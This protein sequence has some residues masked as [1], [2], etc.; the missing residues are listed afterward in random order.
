MRLLNLAVVSVTALGLALASSSARAIEAPAIPEEPPLERYEEIPE[1]WRGY[2]IRVRAAERIADPLQRCLAFPDLPGNRWPEGHAAAHC[3]HHFSGQRP[4]L[5]ELGDLVERGEL[6]RLEEMF[7]A[8]L[9]RHYSGSDSSEQIHDTFN[10]L[11]NDGGAQID[12]ITAAWL[13]R[14]PDS[15][16]ANLA[17]GAY[18]KGAA[19]KARG[20]KYA[21]ET[22]GENLRRMSALVEAAIPYFEKAV[23]INPRLIAAYTGMVQLGML[24]SRPEL[25]E[26]AFEMADELDPACVELANVRMRALQPRWGGSYEQMLAYANRLSRHVPGRPHLAMHVG[27]PFAD[28]GDRLV[29]DKQLTRETLDILEIAIAKG[30]SEEALSDAAN[31]ALNLTDGKPDRIKGLAYLL[32]QSRF[33]ETDAWGARQI[34]WILVGPEPQWSLKYA[35]HALELEPGNAFGHYLVGAGFNNVGRLEEAERAY[36]VAMEDPWHRQ[37][38]L[39]EVA[40]MWL[41]HGGEDERERAVK[42]GPYID[43]LLREYPDDGRGWI[44]RLDRDGMMEMRID[45]EDLRE[46]LGKVNRDDPWQGAHAEKLEKAIEQAGAL[47]NPR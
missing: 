14:A 37:A 9:A 2:L 46:V 13:Q 17:R 22:P 12:R 40:S 4:T 47:A 44:M 43:R 29:A 38:S 23:S 35:L 45:L 5:E 6:A 34:A 42:A 31:V 18:F 11:L 1:P 15:A 21:S 27:A 32:Q 24:D 41:Y 26:R 39:R 30:S 20:T 19:W 25:E 33:Q 28:R 10:Y 16:Y 8:S 3:Q 36:R 7:D